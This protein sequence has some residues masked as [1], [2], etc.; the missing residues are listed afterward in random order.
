MHEKDVYIGPKVVEP[1]ASRSYM[2]QAAL[3]TLSIKADLVWKVKRE[4]FYH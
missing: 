2:H 3:Y 4:E 1:C